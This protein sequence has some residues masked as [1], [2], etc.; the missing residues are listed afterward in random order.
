MSYAMTA[1]H[2][3][4]SEAGLAILKEGGNAVEAMVAAASAIAVA[5]PHMNSLGGDGFWLIQ[6]PGKTPVAIDAAGTACRNASID[7]FRERGLWSLPGRG[8]AA[9]F[10]VAGAVAGWEQ[11]LRV[12][13][14]WQNPLPLSRL[15]APAQELAAKGITVTQTLTDAIAKVQ[16]TTETTPPGFDL[17]LKDGTPLIPGDQFV[18]PVLA[19]TLEHLG[20]A[21]LMDFYR[22]DVA[23]AL[24]ADLEAAGSPIER[25]DLERY[26]VRMPTPLNTEISKG[27][28]YNFPAPTQGVA[29]LMILALYDRVRQ[30]NLSEAQQV[31]LLVECT[32]RAFLDR[33]RWVTDPER[34][35]AQYH[36]LLDPD[37]LDQLAAKV[38]PE[39]ALPWPR[40]A[41]LGDTVWMGALDTQG[42]MVSYIQSVYWEF[43]SAV[44]LPQTGIHWN[45]RGLCFSL[46]PNHHN[47]LAPGCRPFHTLNPALAELADGRRMVY[48]TMGGEG[49]PQTQAAVFNR[50]VNEQIPIDGAVA[51]GRWLLG[52]TWGEG[53]DDLKLEAD[54]AKRIQEELVAKGHKTVVVPERSEMMGHAGAIVLHPDG[55]AEAATDPRSDG[56]AS[57]ITQ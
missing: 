39:Q 51:E 11:A 40:T 3:A 37:Y 57:V 43:G 46:D 4:A 28:L 21:G 36:R 53:S 17:Y 16:S 19:A 14:G 5:Y 23:T 6:E 50:Y 10:T 15:L 26:R 45:N 33:D 7:A 35:S 34:V 13:Q 31:H 24:A 8:P 52:R 44:V 22:G 25:G 47:H 1:P 56:L 49:Q 48:G 29:S 9:A 2:W 18:N 27:R 38:D 12:A 41:E 42:R 32:K 20:R 54:L 30:P 55:T